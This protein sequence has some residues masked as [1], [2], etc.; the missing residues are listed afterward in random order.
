MHQGSIYMNR[1]HQVNRGNQRKFARD[2]VG[3][4]KLE[5][6]RNTAN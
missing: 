4:D 1:H 5:K 3:K 6:A 2:N